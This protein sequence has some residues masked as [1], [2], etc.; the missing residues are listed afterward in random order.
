MPAYAVGHLRP[1]RPDEEVFTYME[2][3]QGTLDAFG[4]RF[5]VHGATVEVLEGTWPGTIVMIE[6]PGMDEA[7]DW[8][9]SSAYRELLPLRTRNLESAV[10]LVDGVGPD[11]DAAVTAARLRGETART[12]TTSG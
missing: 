10:I 9:R 7:R 6:F 4:G 3:V 8:Y 11:Y 12:G 1:S 2:R 5:I